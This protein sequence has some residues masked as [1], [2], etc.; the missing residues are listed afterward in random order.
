M[1]KSTLDVIR[2]MTCKIKEAGKCVMPEEVK[3][4]EVDKE[5]DKDEIPAGFDTPIEEDEDEEIV[6]VEDEELNESVKGKIWIPKGMKK[7]ALHK[8]L[9][10]PEDKKI[11]KSLINKE[12][13]RLTKEAEGDKKLSKEDIKYMKQLVMA[14]NLKAIK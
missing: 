12:I 11:P 10:I 4:E 8:K 6:E 5:L 1:S 3:E 14:K 7:G 2:E 13:A 9:G